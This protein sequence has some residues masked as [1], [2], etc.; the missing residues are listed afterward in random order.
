MRGTRDG[1]PQLLVIE[2]ACPAGD[3]VT[4]GELTWLISAERVLCYGDREITI[5]RGVFGFEQGYANWECMSDDGAIGP[6]PTVTAGW[7]W[8]AGQPRWSLFGAGGPAGPEPPLLVW[9]A[10]GVAVPKDGEAVRV[11]G[12]FDDPAAQSCRL[13]EDEGFAFGQ[14]NDE[15]LNV[16]VCRER[17]VITS[18]ERL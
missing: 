16:L 5:E 15:E 17:F 7:G 8:I 12:H 6:C 14:G 2:P 9:L 1:R 3:A 18:I 4:V 13:L 11:R 10:P